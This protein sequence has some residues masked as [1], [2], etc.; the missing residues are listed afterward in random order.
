MQDLKRYW[1]QVREI[2]AGLPEF[3]WVTD[4]TGFPVQVGC[5]NAARLLQA[6]SHRL[7]TDED[8][9]AHRE[10]VELR[11]RQRAQEKL[12]REGVAVVAV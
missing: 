10:V 5:D 7:A 4:G 2:K 1:D 9:R 12:R 3:V 6:K 8:T 11:T